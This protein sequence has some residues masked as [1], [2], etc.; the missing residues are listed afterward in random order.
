MCDGYSTT[1][2]RSLPSSPCKTQLVGNSAPSPSTSSWS[3]ATE[4]I[5]IPRNSCLDFPGTETEHR[6]LDF[7]YHYTSP[8]LSG[9]FDAKFWNSLLPKVGHSEPTIQHA[10]MAVASVHQQVEVKSTKSFSRFQRDYTNPEVRQF[11]LQQYNKAIASLKKKL[12]EP[13]QSQAVTLM[14]C[15]LFICLEFLRGNTGT[16][17]SH[18]INGVEILNLWRSKLGLP[19]QI[20]TAKSHTELDSIEADLSLI[21]SRLRIQSMLCGRPTSVT[22]TSS[23]EQYLSQSHGFT[24]LREARTT[25][26][27]LMEKCL[28]FLHSSYEFKYQDPSPERAIVVAQC[29][30]YLSRIAKWDNAFKSFLS[31][32]PF[33]QPSDD[34]RASVILRIQSLIA[35]MWLGARLETDE[36]IYD[37]MTESFASVVSLADSLNDVG[38]NQ[39]KSQPVQRGSEHILV[40]GRLSSFAFEMGVIPCLYFVATK[41]RDKIIRRAAVSLLET[42]VPRREGLWDANLVGCV[43]ERLIEIEEEGIEDA[44]RPTIAHRLHD[45]VIHDNDDESC[46]QE[47]TFLRRPGGAGTPWVVRAEEVTW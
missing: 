10:M 13:D 23:S 12:S 37:R 20:G 41:C 31:T 35:Q 3:A 18:L 19:F 7:F 25:M 14:C 9:Y 44:E 17:I 6:Y 45:T 36:M 8:V 22:S 28:Q 30:T 1:P 21:F 40:S 33:K 11:T 16:A 29:D 2:V 27:S 4:R 39:R 26:D 43:A 24:S 5:L 47:I 42:T 46:W 38:T 15:V 32:E 34:W